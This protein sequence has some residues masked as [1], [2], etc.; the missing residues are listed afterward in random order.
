VRLKLL[1]VTDGQHTIQELAATI[2]QIKDAVDFIHI[3]E[4][5]KSVRELLE[6]LERL[7]AGGVEKHK[8]VIHD[9]L[10]L[11]LVEKLSNLHLPGNGFPVNRVREKFP[12]LRL[13]CSVHSLEEALQAERDGADYVLFG[14]IF[15]TRS[16]PGKPPRG[17]KQLEKIKKSVQIPVYAIGGIS[18]ENISGIKKA[19]ADGI[20]V[21]SGIF[22]TEKPE[23]AA[24]QYVK[25]CRE[26]SYET[27]I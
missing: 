18:Q 17:V 7:Q 8:I 4:K 13:G 24:N 14:H 5:A 23:I 19:H 22:S 16:K 25:K 1:A 9:R 27:N 2:I 6:L 11:V 10:D 21:M 20:A 3:R 15:A 12:Q 26:M